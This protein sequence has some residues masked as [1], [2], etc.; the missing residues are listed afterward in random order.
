M[1]GVFKDDPDALALDGVSFQQIPFNE[2]VEQK[3]NIL[4]VTRPRARFAKAG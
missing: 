2:A 4:W 1:L 3:Q